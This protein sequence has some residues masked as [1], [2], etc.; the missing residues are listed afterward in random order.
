M[1]HPLFTAKMFPD[2][3]DKNSTG[4]HPQS[5]FDIPYF[6]S[7]HPQDIFDLLQMTT[8]MVSEI[9]FLDYEAQAEVE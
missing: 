7:L 1:L 5:A 4:L 6:Y 9:V 3:H 2:T 8:L